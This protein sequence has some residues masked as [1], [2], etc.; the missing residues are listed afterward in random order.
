[1]PPGRLLISRKDN[2]VQSKGYFCSY[3]KSSVCPG[4]LSETGSSP[5]GQCT[6]AERKPVLPPR[7][8][9]IKVMLRGGGVDLKQVVYVTTGRTEEDNPA[10]EIKAFHLFAWDYFYWRS[11]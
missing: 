4:S 1:M 8:N 7:S 6:G 2:S 11:N 5:G 10:S 3:F 9:Y